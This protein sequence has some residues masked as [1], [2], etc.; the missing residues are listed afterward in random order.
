M[1]SKF[2]Y[3]LY[4]FIMWIERKN[5]KTSEGLPSF[6]KN[7]ALNGILK[8]CN[9]RLTATGIF[10]LEV[11]GNIIPDYFMPAWTNYNEVIN[12]CSYDITDYLTKNNKITVTVADGWY[13]GN[14]GYNVGKN[15]YGDKKRLYA[16]IELCYANGTTE[17]IVSDES[18]LVKNSAVVCADFFDGEKIDFRIAETADKSTDNAIVSDF[19]ANFQDFACEP[20][21]AREE[22]IP[23]VIF[24]ENGVIRL[25][26]HK[27]FAG[28]VS[29]NAR[30]ARG[31]KIRV[32]YAE[33]LCDNGELYTENLRKAKCT[34]E[35]I[36]SDKPCVFDPRFTYHGF[37]YA[38][39][40]SNGAEITHIKGKLLT[41]NIKYG[42]E[43]ECSDEV[44]NGVFKMALNGQK[45][46]FIAVPTDCP[47]RD[48]RLGWTGDAEVFCN[49]AMFNADCDKF[50]AYY[51]KLVRT[52][53]L[54]DGRIPSFAPSFVPVA[55]NTAG[56][57]A[58]ADCITV[59]PYF[60]YLHY[61]DKSVITDNLA[62]AEKWVEYY[63]AK[64]KNYIVH[65]TNNFGD[66]LSPAEVTDCNLINQCFFGYSLKLLA[67]MEKIVGNKAKSDKYANIY[68]LAKKAFLSEYTENG[69][70]KN[71]TQTAYALAYAVGYLSAKEVRGELVRLINANGKKLSTGFIG[72][73]FLL[74]ALCEIGETELAYTIIR[75]QEYPSWGYMLKN[76]ATTVWERWNGYTKENGFETPDMN[77]FNHYSLGSCTEWLYSFVL[78]IK[79]SAESDE[80]T[81]SPSFTK[82]LTYARGKY[83]SVNGD[84]SV[85]WRQENSAFVIEINADEKVKFRCDFKDKEVIS[86]EKRGNTV[87]AVI[88]A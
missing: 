63:L 81:V 32:K 30:G 65:I 73:R 47:Q 86:Y 42:G 37:R 15:I 25:D 11:N 84:I 55:P 23:E 70:I 71:G 54:A 9:I 44:M 20:V 35:V 34:D 10:S 67:E 24:S 40:T 80:I 62:A 85:G 58:W 39:I 29:F 50:F 22:I 57:P 3:N 68:E 27:N 48:E 79:L 18:W 61:R 16:E 74:P 28:V 60:H 45:S 83:A 66:W 33:M 5:D 26:F 1:W 36:L 12:L 14:L 59:I 2:R 41:Q 51:L 38:E 82:G 53:A 19:A 72:V 7:F 78:G 46:N 6:V 4:G 76:G 77:S 21:R 49:S 64:S 87:K 8:K 56:V 52:D 43:F 13:A 31:E 69:K 88:K 75:G 17:K